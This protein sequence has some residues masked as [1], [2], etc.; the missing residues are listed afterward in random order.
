MNEQTANTAAQD[1]PL[2]AIDEDKIAEELRKADAIDTLREKMIDVWIPGFKV[3]C[4]PEEAE[5]AGAF[6][7]DAMS[8]QDA[9]DSTIVLVALYDDDQAPAFRTEGGPSANLPTFVDPK[10]VR[11]FYDWK[12]SESLDEGHRAQEGA[13]GL[14]HADQPNR[15]ASR[16]RGVYPRL[17]RHARVGRAR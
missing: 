9:L 8:L 4:D 2:A 7:E 13:G 6:V 3:E 1:E 5:R 11:S 12:P 16:C 14:T 17:L 15:G 10:S